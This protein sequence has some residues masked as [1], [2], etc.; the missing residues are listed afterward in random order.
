MR[1]WPGDGASGPC[2]SARSWDSWGTMC[3]SRT[4]GISGPRST[5][6]RHPGQ[7]REE[8]GELPLALSASEARLRRWRGPAGQDGSG[9]LEVGKA[10][11]LF[12]IDGDTLELAGALHDPANLARPDRGF[13]SGTPHHGGRRGG[14]C[15]GTA[16][17]NRRAETGEEAERVCDRRSDRGVQPSIWKA[18]RLPSW[19]APRLVRRAPP[20]HR[21][22]KARPL[23]RPS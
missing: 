4:A 8:E 2:P 1:S 5:R 22:R 14:L 16:F 19:A 23:S 18:S 9:S 10:A 11:D 12:H 6:P 3:G 15:G 20:V 13:R 21:R 7:S 17:R